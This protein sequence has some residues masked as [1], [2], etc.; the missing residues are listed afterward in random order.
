MDPFTILKQLAYTGKAFKENEPGS[1]E[2][3]ITQS[4]ALI[5]ALELPSEFIQHTFWAE[6]AQS[7][8]LR[9]AVDVRLFQHLKEAPPKGLS[10]VALSKKTGVEVDLLVRL[11]RHLVAMNIL[12]FHSG[13]FHGTAL[14]NSLAVERYQDSI[15]HCYNAMRPALNEIPAYFKKVAYRSPTSG[16]TDGIF[17]DAH[18]TDLGFFD[19]IVATPP[20]LRHFYSFM[21]TYH[22]GKS[23]FEE[24]FY[25]VSQR[26]ICGFDVEVGDALLVDVGG[27]RGHDVA[28]FVGVYGNLPGKVVLQDRKPVIAG[29]SNGAVGRAFEVQAYDFFTPQPVKGARA[30][31]LHSILHDWCDKDAVRILGNLVPA[32]VRSYSRVLLNEIVLSE[33][34]PTLA[35]TSMDMIMLS[36]FGVRER[37]EVEWRRILEQV[38]LRVIG[39]YTYPGVAESL[40]EAELA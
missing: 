11:S 18:G 26:L 6:P 3:L 10:P 21:S 4:R 25:P 35:T 8:I 24:G 23:W 30:Y 7:A 40:I 22:T 5:A 34:K 16:G 32:L 39:I 19:W 1:R 13:T 15:L 33:A 12:A 31:S 29:I 36:H 17:Q 38:G 9:L 28:A 2:A 37:T 27:G 20:Q 14:S